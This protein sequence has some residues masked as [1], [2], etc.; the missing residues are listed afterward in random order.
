MARIQHQTIPRPIGFST[1]SLAYGDYR[2]ALDVLRIS[3]ATA[4]ELSALREAELVP[5]MSDLPQ[6]DL[7]RFRH[8]AVHAPSLL[9][10]FSEADL[11]N[12]LEPA[13]ARRYPVIVHADVIK[14]PPIWRKFK[15][16]LLI[17]NMDKRKK[18]GRTVD[19]LRPLFTQ[20]PSARLCLDL[21]HARQVDPSLSEAVALLV[22]FRNK[23]GQIHLS[24]LDTDSKHKS[25]SYA[26]VSAL[27]MLRGLF[28][29]KAPII[30]EF[31]AQP[32]ELDGHIQL[33]TE[34]LRS[35]IRLASEAV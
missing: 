12:R 9:N 8:I 18:T 15:S 20:L 7:S 28:P 30:L 32:N 34:S 5:L 11:I 35:E 31:I 29:Y 21:A 27:Q 24:E 19:E 16:L 23:I 22:E 2:S 33:V 3:N 17:E 10:S 1:G 26:A 25:L 14:T 4:V 6:L 13:I